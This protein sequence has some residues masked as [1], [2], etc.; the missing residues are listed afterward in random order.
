MEKGFPITS[1]VASAHVCCNQLPSSRASGPS[2]AKGQTLNAEQ[3]AANVERQTLNAKRRP[4]KP[5][6]DK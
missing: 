4:F 6:G 2:N 5:S 3:Q 1:M